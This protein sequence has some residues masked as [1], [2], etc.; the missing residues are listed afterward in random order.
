MFYWVFEIVCTTVF[1]LVNALMSQPHTRICKM[2]FVIKT[3][4]PIDCKYTTNSCL[5]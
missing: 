5:V 4:V 2:K 1:S 3:T